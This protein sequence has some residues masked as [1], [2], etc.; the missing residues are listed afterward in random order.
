M[1]SPKKDYKIKKDTKKINGRLIFLSTI[2][3]F[4]FF[5][6]IYSLYKIQII[7]FDFYVARAGLQHNIYNQ[8]KAKRG[9]I[10]LNKSLSND[11]YSIASNKDFSALYI[12]PRLIGEDYTLKLIENFY[13]NFHQDDVI[14]EVDEFLEKKDKE[15]LNNELRYIDSLNLSFEEKEAKKEEVKIRKNNLKFN[16]EWL[17]F[18]KIQRDLEIEERRQF[19]VNDYFSKFKNSDKYS[20][21]LRRKV[22]RDELLNFYFNF[23]RE[24]FNLESADDLFIKNGKILI[25]NNE[26]DI[27]NEINGFY[28]EWE[29]LRYY[30]E[31]NLFSHISGFSNFDNIGHYGLESFFNDE[32]V[33]K[34][35]FL[36]ADRGTYKG[37][38]M[39]IDK[40]EY[41]PP[42][43]GHNLVLTIDYGAQIHICNKLKEYS[44][45]YLF[46]SASITVMDPQTGKI[47]ALCT[48][49][50]FDVNNYQLISDPE[51]FDNQ[52]IS[53]QYEPGSVFKTITMAI[54]IDQGKI[55]PFTEYED[56]GQLFISGWPKP[57]KNSDFDKRGGHGIVSMNYV[58]ENSLNTGAIFAAE[59]VGKDIF[60]DYLKKFGFGE[61]TGIELSG[62]TAGNIRNITTKNVKDID[63][64]TASFGQGIAVTPLQM[65]SSYAVIAN[66][67]I[68]M[69][70]YI[71]EKILDDSG[72]ILQEIEPKMIRRVISEDAS[73]AVS[74]MLVNVVENGHAVGAQVEG[75]YIGGKTGT[76]QIP[77]SQGG[78]LEGQY[79]HNFVGY[80]PIDNPKF[81]ILVKFD[82]PKITSF[83]ASSASP[84][85]GEISEFLLKY[86]QV[87]KNR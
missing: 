6:L 51:I 41:S 8:L 54:A 48:W 40:K 75:Y 79:I 20:R 76:A 1:V 87:Q 66:K 29:N 22:D 23:L 67:G 4:M 60:A 32:L 64:S 69:K 71:V 10:Y 21:L 5:S 36:L 73:L 72:N 81:A 15:D 18:R 17:E 24:D 70:P 58:L 19:V 86:F 84:A 9:E 80:A 39:I 28:Y 27:T 78:Y 16:E 62:E 12:I 56:K 49:P 14:K 2:I 38:R 53:Y 3:F 85:F 11:F 65:L 63:F 46:D 26:N 33:G 37:K 59:K 44:E 74:A 30:P 13:I 52:V 7:N 83:S 31:K 34:D 47:I 35:G 42:Q 77:S 61:R 45:R 68:L 57:I 25:I 82:N 50:D 55:T 43:N